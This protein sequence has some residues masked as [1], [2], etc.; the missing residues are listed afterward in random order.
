MGSCCAHS[1]MNVAPTIAPPHSIARCRV[2]P[3]KADDKLLTFDGPRSDNY[4]CLGLI[5]SRYE[6]Q[7]LQNFNLVQLPVSAGAVVVGF[8]GTQQVGGP[9]RSQGWCWSVR[10]PACWG[11]VS[12]FRSIAGGC[13]A[14]G[15]C[16][17]AA[18]YDVGGHRDCGPRP[19]AVCK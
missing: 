2:T 1:A 19:I 16:V 4:V 13:A 6:E 8:D 3:T 11:D 7:V 14:A 9:R 15:F 10:S 5:A 18:N 12:R 17:D